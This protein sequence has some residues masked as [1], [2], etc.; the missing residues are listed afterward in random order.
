MLQQCTTCFG[1]CRGTP[2]QYITYIKA[3]P[4]SSTHLCFFWIECFLWLIFLPRFLE[5]EARFPL[6]RKLDPKICINWTDCFGRTVHRNFAI[7][8]HCYPR[9]NGSSTL[10]AWI[11]WILEYI[12]VIDTL[13][14]SD[15]LYEWKWNIIHG[16]YNQKISSSVNR[17]VAENKIGLTHH[18]K[19]IHHVWRS[20]KVI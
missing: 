18:A 14:A 19:P 4:L 1:L 13:N 12:Q 20:P 5:K 9:I 6:T 16:I 8:D 3:Y 10:D 11:T 2:V 7:P 15:I 17:S